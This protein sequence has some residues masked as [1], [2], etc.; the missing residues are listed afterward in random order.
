MITGIDQA[1]Y[2]VG[3]WKNTRSKIY[4]IKT[5]LKGTRISF[6]PLL[7]KCSGQCF[8]VLLD[9]I[10]NKYFLSLLLYKITKVPAS[11][12]QWYLEK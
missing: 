9:F 2:F 7:S 4:F 1:N 12:S 6:V 11:F 10:A 8:F 5:K 3:I